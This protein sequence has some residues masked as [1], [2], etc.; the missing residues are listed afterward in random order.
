MMTSLQ[1]HEGEGRST[2]ISA[3]SSPVRFAVRKYRDYKSKQRE[4]ARLN[5]TE[6]ELVD[7]QKKIVSVDYFR[8][9]IQNSY[10][11]LI[12]FKAKK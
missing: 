11:Q 2:L 5:V 8:I 10:V 1:L 6:R 9:I 12:T 3:L 4:R 7:I